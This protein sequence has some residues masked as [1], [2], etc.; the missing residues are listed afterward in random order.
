M[1]ATLNATSTMSPGQADLFVEQLRAVFRAVV[2]SGQGVV[3]SGRSATLVFTSF[4][5]EAFLEILTSRPI[6]DFVMTYLLFFG[7]ALP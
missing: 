5:K 4:S 3:H 7:G 2:G 6:I 1:A